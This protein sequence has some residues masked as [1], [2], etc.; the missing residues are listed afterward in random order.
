[1]YEALEKIAAE[2][3]WEIAAKALTGAYTA[4]SNA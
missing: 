4:L 3:R 2:K 1:M